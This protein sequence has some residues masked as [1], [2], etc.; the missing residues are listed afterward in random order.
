MAAACAIPMPRRVVIGLQYLRLSGESASAI[1]VSATPDCPA[2]YGER[3]RRRA[4]N[5]ARAARKLDVEMDPRARGSYMPRR[6]L[7]PA[8]LAI[9]YSSAVAS[10]RHRG[11]RPRYASA[12]RQFPH[13]VNRAA[14]A[15][16]PHRLSCSRFARDT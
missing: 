11:A 8:T 13:V 7:R 14:S 4:R 3:R 10:I 6:A 9:L 2:G 1:F 16:G 5:D 15:D 12:A